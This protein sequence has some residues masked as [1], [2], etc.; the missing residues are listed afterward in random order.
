MPIKGLTDTAQPRFRRLGKLR[1]GDEKPN[2]KQP[3]PELQYWRF[4]S[5]TPEIEAAFVAAYGETPSEV[6][7]YLPFA[8]IADNWS[9]WQE[10]WV[11][12]GA[13]ASLRR[14][15]VYQVAGQRRRL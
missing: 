1:K 5:D 14:G 15:D 2:D 11:A 7:V 10:K 3:G 6:D 4:T 9:T 12:G 8:K 13:R